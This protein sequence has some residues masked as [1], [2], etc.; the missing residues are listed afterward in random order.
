MRV[1]LLLGGLGIALLIL[2]FGLVLQNSFAPPES[3]H[4]FDI[5]PTATGAPQGTRVETTIRRETITPAAWQAFDY[6]SGALLP[7]AVLAATE[8]GAPSYVSCA[9]YASELYVSGSAEYFLRPQ[10]AFAVLIDE[11]LP[12]PGR[13]RVRVTA[14]TGEAVHNEVVSVASGTIGV[15]WQATL[16]VG[17]SVE[18]TGEGDLWSG[19]ATDVVLAAK[20]VD[21]PFSWVGTP[22]VHVRV[23]SPAPCPER[24]TTQVHVASGLS[25][26]ELFPKPLSWTLDGDKAVSRFRC[27]AAT[28]EV[29]FIITDVRQRGILARLP[30]TIGQ[31]VDGAPGTSPQS[32]IDLWWERTPNGGADIARTELRVVIE[33]DDARSGGQ[34]RALGPGDAQETWKFPPNANSTSIDL[35]SDAEELWYFGLS[36]IAMCALIP[37]PIPDTIVLAA[38]DAG[39]GQLE[40]ATDD[41]IRRVLIR[42]SAAT[43]GREARIANQ[44]VTGSPTLF[45]VP[46]G[47]YSVHGYFEGSTQPNVSVAADV[48]PETVSHVWLKGPSRSDVRIKWP[49][50]RD[51]V[52][53]CVEQRGSRAR[54]VLW[55]GA[56]PAAGELRVLATEDAHELRIV[57]SDALGKRIWYDSLNI[58]NTPQQPDV[59]LSWANPEAWPGM[60]WRS[61]SGGTRLVRVVGSAAVTEDLRYILRTDAPVWM[62]V[63]PGWYRLELGGTESLVQ[64]AAGE[65]LELSDLDPGVMAQTVEFRGSGRRWTVGARMSDDRVVWSLCEAWA[66]GVVRV[67]VPVTTQW[68]LAA[69]SYSGGFE[70]AEVQR[71]SWEGKTVDLRGTA[72]SS[73]LILDTRV[74]DVLKVAHA[75]VREFRGER[76][77]KLPGDGLLVYKGVADRIQARTSGE[78][79]VIVRG[80]DGQEVVCEIGSSDASSRGGN[81]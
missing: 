73:T 68:L 53:M 24:G 77:W 57:R 63:W 34:L 52:R 27:L 70:V 22:V 43:A 37:K 38:Q 67:S 8:A 40:V 23:R 56:L 18:I 28:G 80:R 54:A 58:G 44:D 1:D 66:D 9:G 5:S 62:P 71:S 16:R 4:R 60:V 59:Q 55:S 30:W 76:A 33:G 29:Q 72:K 21:A 39:L 35:R 12:S 81:R 10:C 65:V 49:P 45:R 74:V 50:T 15:A 41:E 46:A 61:A 14:D 20:Q 32:P 3:P 2:I 75:H 51:A 25:S 78:C 48:K 11:P 6:L 31:Q 36:N 47:A 42:G 79:N 69:T 13:L 17:Q 19:V 7:D 26:T 64:F